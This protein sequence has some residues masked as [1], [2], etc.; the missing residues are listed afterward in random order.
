MKHIT[1]LQQEAV[2]A[3]NVK[4]DS[5]VVDATL[6]AGGHA[7]LILNQLSNQG[8]YV[9][10]DVDATAIKALADNLTGTATIHLVHS[11]FAKIS[12]VLDELGMAS[13]D[14]IL[15]DL[16][17]RTEQFTDG[18]RGFSFTDESPLLMTYGKPE[19]YSFVASD[20]VNGWDEEDIANVLY[21]YG[22]ERYSRRIAK[23]IVAT[24]LIRPIDTAKTLAEVIASAVPASYRHGRI[25]PATK[26]F[27]A[28]RIAV[29]D[30]FAVLESFLEQSWQ[31]LNHGGRL[32]V[33]TFHSLEDR[34]VKLSFR[35]F[36]HDHTGVLVTKKPITPSH[37]ERVKN[38][39][40]RSAKLRII[41]KI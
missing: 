6:G 31:L 28:L 21:G 17:W 40:S 32:A 18:Q 13:V 2:A 9:G 14:A 38:P 29:N 5:V 33:I 22:E 35:S 12:K 4:P 10:I 37:E 25:N 39:R 34:I 26:S 41:Q 3:L 36:T 30:E 27:Q 11:N 20:I 16:G 24:R 23:A 1:V 8:S 19:D 15:A 7:Q